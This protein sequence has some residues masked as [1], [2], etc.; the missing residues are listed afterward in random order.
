MGKNPFKITP[1]IKVYKTTVKIFQLC[2]GAP[3]PLKTLRTI[4]SGDVARLGSICPPPNP[5][6][7][8]APLIVII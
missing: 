4:G 6:T 2:H 7:T 1:F 5:S 3:T 8:Q